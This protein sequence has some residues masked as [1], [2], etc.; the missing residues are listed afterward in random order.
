M[1]IAVHEPVDL[2]GRR[3]ED[4]AQHQPEAALAD[5]PAHTRA[6]ASIPTSR[7]TAPSDRCRGA[8]AGA[9][10]RRRGAASCCRQRRRRASSVRRRAGRRARSA[11]TRD[12]RSAGDAAGCRR[13]GPPCRN[14][15][16]TPSGLP[17]SSQYS[18]WRAST[19]SLPDACGSISGHRNRRAKGGASR[20]CSWPALP[21]H[22]CKHKQSAR[23]VARRM[24]APARDRALVVDRPFSR[25]CARRRPSASAR[26]GPRCRA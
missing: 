25:A 21:V 23:A 16:G 5:A 1:R 15:I 7:R 8:R 19:G 17:H 6:R 11:R 20:R 18:V 14:T 10:C 24:L 2:G 4:A 12:R 22:R 9:R 3:E 13:P 26:R